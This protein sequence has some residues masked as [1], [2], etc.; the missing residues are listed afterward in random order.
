MPL[1]KRNYKLDY[2]DRL[3]AV[4]LDAKDQAKPERQ[5]FYNIWFSKWQGE[6]AEFG[7]GVDPSSHRCV[8]ERDAGRTK[9]TTKMPFCI[10]FAHGRCSRGSN[11][12]FLHRIP[13]DT[14]KPV[15]TMDCFGRD[16][17]RLNRK[18]MGGVGSFENRCRTVYVGNIGIND[19][20]EE[21]LDAH[22]GEWGE[23]E[24]SIFDV[25]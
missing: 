23:I 24:N 8:V 10:H 3:A 21:I 6:G 19:H 9:A 1:K 22:F 16:K 17:F 14:D 4:Q 13:L 7:K 15:T 5:A 2:Q 12:Q 18:D 11:C 25:D 20:M